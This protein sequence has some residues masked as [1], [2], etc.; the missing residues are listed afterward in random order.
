MWE[1]RSQA[2]PP[3]YIPAGN[4]IKESR[5]WTQFHALWETSVSR[6]TNGG[7]LSLTH[8]TLH[9]YRIDAWAIRR[10]WLTFVNTLANSILERFLHCKDS[11]I[12]FVLLA[13]GI[14]K[15]AAVNPSAVTRVKVNPSTH[16]PE[17]IGSDN[18]RRL[19]I[20]ESLLIQ[21]HKLELNANIPSMP[22]RI[23]N[24]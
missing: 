1:R 19:Q 5:Y 12:C 21:E 24:L 16:N 10:P 20:L 13:Y 15:S 2:F 4:P 23:F 11:K 3:H 8:F 9:C 6:L 22:L 17:V 7:A 18:W 14:A